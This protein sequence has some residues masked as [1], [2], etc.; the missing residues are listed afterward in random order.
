MSTQAIQM[1]AARAVTEEGVKKLPYDDKTGKP[2]AAP[3]GN[4]S[5][6]IGFNLM[7]CGSI[8]LF[9]VMLSYLCQGLDD[10]LKKLTWYQNCNIVQQSVFIDIAYNAG[11][12]GLLDPVKGFPKMIHYASIYDWTSAAAECK[13]LDA[14]L[15]ASRY[16]PLR[17]LLLES[18][19][20]V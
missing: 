2:V 7:V 14:E 8:G 17:K 1:F 11:L 20:N 13:V 10:E 12:E 9:Q 19:T 6:G 5:W 4:L 15:D 16:A 3:V 18:V